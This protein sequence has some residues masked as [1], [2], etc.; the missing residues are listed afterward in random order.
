MAYLHCHSCAWSQDDFWEWKWTWRLWQSRP[1]GYNPISLMIED[2]HEYIR[3]RYVEWDSGFAKRNGWKSSRIH[4]WRVL[5]WSWK[6][7]FKRFF[8]MKW[9][10]WKDW[11]KHRKTAVCPHCGARNFDID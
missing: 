9:W 10:T 11:Q 7:H 2:I 4:S 1:F 3:P 5:A 6:I 8:T